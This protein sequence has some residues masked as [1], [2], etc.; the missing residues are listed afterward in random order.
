MSWTLS[1]QNLQTL[2]RPNRRRLTGLLA[3]GIFPSSCDAACSSYSVFMRTRRL[4]R[5]LVL[6]LATR[7]LHGLGR[8]GHAHRRFAASHELHPLRDHLD[9][10]ALLAVL[11]FPVARLEPP[12]HHDRAALVEILPAAFGLL[13]PH[14]HG[15]EAHLVALLAALCRVVPVDRQPEVRDRG[16]A[17]RIP[18]LRRARQIPHQEHLVQARHQALSSTVAGWAFGVPRT[19]F[20][21]GTR[22]VMKRSTCSFRRSCRSN[23]LMV[24]GSAAHSITA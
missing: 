17:R 24:A 9:H 11:R 1:I 8:S 7:S 13:S 19:R 4:E 2:R 18:E 10:V 16:A 6:S 22:V 14:H 12:F 23:S 5:N 21:G 20:F 15:E 3:G